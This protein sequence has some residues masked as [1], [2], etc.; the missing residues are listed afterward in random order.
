MS[1]ATLLLS[2]TAVVM[3]LTACASIAPTAEQYVPPEVGASWEIVQTST[4]SYGG[5]ARHKIV[6][7]DNTPWQGKSALTFRGPQ[8]QTLADPTSGR[9]L[10]IT[11]LDGTP[12]MTFEPPMG[13]DHPVKV[14]NIYS[15]RQK[16]TMHAAKRT[17][18]F[19]QTCTVQAYEQLTLTAGTFGAFRVRCTTSAGHDE[20]HWIDPARGLFVKQR[21]IRTE[22]HMAGLGTQDN[23]IVSFTPASK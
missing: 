21:L 17:V 14:G 5:D 18:E 12:V 13:W 9:W 22:Q 3:G 1:S 8:T 2:T 6:R 20:T 23:E 15:T 16:V 7:A 11:R 19:D 10:A 4:G